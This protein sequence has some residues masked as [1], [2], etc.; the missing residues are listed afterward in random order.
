MAKVSLIGSSHD[1]NKN[2]YNNCLAYIRQIPGAISG[3]GGHNS[4][5]K[6]A[7]IV[8][9]GFMLNEGEA[10]EVLRDYN[11]RC[12]PPWS[13]SELLHKL[14]SAIANPGTK[15]RGY[16]LG[17][18]TC[19]DPVLSKLGKLKP[20]QSHNWTQLSNGTKSDILELSERLLIGDQ[21]L[22]IARDLGLLKFWTNS[23][24][25]RVWS[26]T[27]HL[28]YVRQD[29]CMVGKLTLKNGEQT[30]SR[31]MGNPSWPVGLLK[32][33]NKFVIILAE[34]SSDFLAAWHLIFTC[35]R[36]YDTGAVCMLGATQKIHQEALKYFKEKHVLIFPDM[37]KSGVKASERWEKQLKNIASDI[38]IYDFTG[39]KT[40][41]GESVGDLRD[42]LQVN[43]D[44]W[45]NDPEVRDPIPQK[46][47]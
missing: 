47:V 33:Q 36:L 14:K 19:R 30:K 34:G 8:V 22:Q 37:D 21:G 32:N 23:D 27:D 45:E 15:P 29:R 44:D 2:F 39:L 9:N 40:T 4:T 17:K 12:D 18:S 31:T 42:F 26:I 46:K 6:V 7:S 16:L 20:L 5:F 11:N 25:Q 28:Q 3:Q 41:S 38:S 1:M 35:E 43:Y 13:E 10:M 24:G